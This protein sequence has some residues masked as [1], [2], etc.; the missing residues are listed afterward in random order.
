[1]IIITILL[2]HSHFPKKLAGA[3]FFECCKNGSWF[4]N[5]W[6]PLTCK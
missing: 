1:M 5:G 6:E 4:Q 3:K 2:I